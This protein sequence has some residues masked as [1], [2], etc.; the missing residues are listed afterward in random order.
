MTSRSFSS[1]QLGII[2][3]SY[4]VY[5][6]SF[7]LYLRYFDDNNMQ[8]N[9]SVNVIYGCVREFLPVWY[10]ACW[11]WQLAVYQI[12]KNSESNEIFQGGGIFSGVWRFDLVVTRWP[13]ST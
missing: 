5:V 7:C 8:K 3:H 10:T 2:V 11:L 12:G 1:T 9:V 4:V 6:R 13:R